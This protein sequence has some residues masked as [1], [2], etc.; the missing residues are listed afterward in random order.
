MSDE[1]RRGGVGE[2]GEVGPGQ[3]FMHYV[4]M[5][6]LIDKLKLLQYEENFLKNLGFKPLSR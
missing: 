2:E 6:D 5:E 3:L 1:G 4:I